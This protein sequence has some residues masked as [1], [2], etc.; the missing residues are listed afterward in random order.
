MTGDLILDFAG[1]LA[2]LVSAYKSAGFV[3]GVIAGF[4]SVVCIGQKLEEAESWELYLVPAAIGVILGPVL[5]FGLPFLVEKHLGEVSL[6]LVFLY[7]WVTGAVIGL[8]LGFHFFRVWQPKVVAWR[9]RITQRS[10]QERDKKTDVRTVRNRLPETPEL[11]NVLDHYQPGFITVGLDKA[12][13]PVRVPI[14]QWTGSH[15]QLAGTTG[16]GKGV[17]A[18]M[19]L[20]QAVLEGEAVIALDP[21]NDEWAP[22]ALYAA[23]LHANVPYHFVD[24]RDGQPMQINPLIGASRAELKEMFLAAFSLG[25]KGGDADFYRLNDRKAAGAVAEF[26]ARQENPS[27]SG[28]YRDVQNLPE[29]KAAAGFW[30]AYEEMAELESINAR[31]VGVDLAKVIEQGGV[32]YVVGSMRNSPVMKAQRMLMI[33]LVQIC[34]KR[35]RMEKPRSVCVFLDE[36]KYHLSKPA[37]EIFGAARD[38]GLHALVAHQSLSDLRDVPADLDADAVVGS[39][40]ENTAIKLIY[41]LQDPDTAEWIAKRSGIKLVDEEVRHI[42]RNVAQSEI[43]DDDRMIRQSETYL[44]D[45]NMLMNLPERVAVLFSDVLP[46]FIGT[47]PVPVNKDR[48]AISVESFQVSNE[49]GKKA[50]PRQSAVSGGEEA[51][52][53]NPLEID[54]GD[55]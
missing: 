25:E 22:H 40:I 52:S 4:F 37:M 5:H 53:N 8:A 31:S 47:S 9:E 15:I 2:W 41:R 12:G 11:F 38:K 6:S 49:P 36:L 30:G 28:C 7:V 26:M 13:H 20:S 54:F 10:D 18:Q 24:L 50:S 23:A 17:A 19:A 3:F 14:K 45:T 39:V 29:V 42:A 27:F 55:E 16:A 44:V 34:E 1:V 51:L 21:K 46:H 35:D 48:A 32:V 43:M 33:R